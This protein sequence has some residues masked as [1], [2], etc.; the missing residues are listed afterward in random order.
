MGVALFDMDRTLVRKDTAS[1]YVRYQR[2]VGEAGWRDAAR[3]AWW[4]LQYTFGAIDAER[5]AEQA[6]AGFRGKEERWMV[7]HC[8]TWFRD[9]VL[10]HVTDRAR[11]TVDRHRARGDTLL[12]VT[13]ATRYAAE[14]LARELGIEHV[15]CTRLEVDK[16]G[17]FTGQVVKPMCFG[18]GK[19]TLTEAYAASRDFAIDEATFY[20]DSITDRPLLEH[21][22]TPIAVN[23]DGRLKRLATKRGWSIERW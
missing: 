1:L 3:V 8:T 18:G 2:D 22:G 17:R 14:P 4:L 21:V 20:T 11:E 16:E 5:I 19:I 12:I 23:P 7:E 15:V 9:Y 13:G 6:L 10:P